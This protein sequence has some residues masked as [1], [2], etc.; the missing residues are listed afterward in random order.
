[1]ADAAGEREYIDFLALFGNNLIESGAFREAACIYKL[2]ASRD[3]EEKRWLLGRC[4]CLLCASDVENA[5]QALAKLTAARIADTQAIE[6][7]NR[8]LQ[9][10]LQ[11][12]RSGK[13]NRQQPTGS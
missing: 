5:A 2:L 10:L 4:H 12:S 11:R 9:L 1:M 3:P 7:L 13:A 8:R 6:R